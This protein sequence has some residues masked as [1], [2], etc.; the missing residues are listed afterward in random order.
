M[1]TL[2]FVMLFAIASI[3]LGQDAVQEKTQQKNE[4]TTPQAKPDTPAT[5]ADPKDDATKTG[6]VAVPEALNFKMK[7]LDGKDVQLSGYAG[8]VVVFV[9]TASRCGLTPQYEQLQK[10]HEKYS[11][12]GL[13]IIGVPC[14]QFGGQEPGTEAEIKAFCTKNYGVTFDMLAKVDVNGKDQ[15]D[16]YKYLTSLDLKPKGKGDV[17][18]NFEKFVLDRDGKVIARFGPRTKPDSDEFVTIVEGAI[19]Q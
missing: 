3:S 11:E 18:W 8:K 10:L 2:T 15:A 14:N 19:G 17:S 13:A 6:A 1:K 9:N 7:S 4:Q 16:L 12:K 5:A